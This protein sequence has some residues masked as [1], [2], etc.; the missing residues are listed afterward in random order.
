M[1]RAV[2]LTGIFCSGGLVMR[3]QE[4]AAGGPRSLEDAVEMLD[5]D[6]PAEVEAGRQWLGLHG[7]KVV[8]GLLERIRTGK[9]REQ[10]DAAGE[11]RL[12]LGRW[13]RALESA[14]RAGSIG[15]PARPV[16]WLGMPEERMGHRPEAREIRETLQ[17]ASTG[18]MKVA[19]QAKK[20][21]ESSI[22]VASALGSL[23][24]PLNAVAD[25]GTMAWLLQGLEKNGNESYY[26]EMLVR[27]GGYYM[28]FPRNIEYGFTACGPAP[29]GSPKELERWAAAERLKKRA[30][31][32]E[33][34]RQLKE[35]WRVMRPMKPEE[36]AA[37]AIE[38]WRTQLAGPNFGQFFPGRV[39]ELRP[40]V[41]L[42]LPAVGPLRA[43]QARETDLKL[44]A[45]WETVIVAITGHED[46]ALMEQL[47]KGDDTEARLACDIVRVGQ[48]R[49]WLKQLDELLNRPEG[50]PVSAASWAIATAHGDEGLPVLKRR[51]EREPQDTEAAKVC[52]QVARRVLRSRVSRPAPKLVDAEQ[53]FSV[54]FGRQPRLLEY[55]DPS[56][57]RIL[58]WGVGSKFDFQN[59]RRSDNHSICLEAG[60]AELAPGGEHALQRTKRYLEWCGFEVEVVE[61]RRE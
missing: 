60:P 52:D 36:R 49:A 58:T 8:G 4:P 61:S 14:D 41:R 46:A 2:L 9:P 20:S 15:E 42:G 13:L 29:V 57:D 21:D 31:R 59:P 45:A 50:G 32:D 56:E 5:S 48:S 33:E 6:R 55:H 37:V 19:N 54:Q 27:V 35:D 47:W 23:C 1:S 24:E 38:R 3:A 34:I 30:A 11:L 53:G 51:A 22:M 12:V 7:G 25:D 40:L 16:A 39:D 43:Q 44:K 28:G 26:R 17:R 18:L 10:Y